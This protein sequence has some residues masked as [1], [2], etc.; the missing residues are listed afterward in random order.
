VR[1]FAEMEVW[2]EG[3]FEKVNK[4]IADENEKTSAFALEFHAGRNHFHDGGGE[5][6]AGAYG[7]EVHKVAPR[8][9]A[10]DEDGASSD[11]GEGGSEAENDG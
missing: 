11:I 3:V 1:F 8:P 2:R 7:H 6:E 9:R 4:K 5:H 10:L